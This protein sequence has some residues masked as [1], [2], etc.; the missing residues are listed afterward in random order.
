[1]CENHSISCVTLAEGVDLFNHLKPK[2]GQQLILLGPTDLITKLVGI[3]R[4][5]TFFKKLCLYDQIGIRH[6][7]Q[8]LKRFS[9]PFY[10][11]NVTKKTIRNYQIK[12][13]IIKR[14]C[15]SISCLLCKWGNVFAIELACY[16][17]HMRGNIKPGYLKT[18][19]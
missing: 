16:L 11:Q 19:A 17:Q 9:G 10:C 7:G 13:F 8:F 3:T 12:A 4:L 1:M 15:C 2:R 14:E 6:S 18:L 5:A